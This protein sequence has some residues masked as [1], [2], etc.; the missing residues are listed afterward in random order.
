MKKATPEEFVRTWQTSNSTQE[1]ATALKMSRQSVISRA[2]FYRNKGIPLKSFAR[3][4]E[5][6]NVE[7][8]TKLANELV[9]KGK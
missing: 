2:G 7:K 3:K 1:V 5:H 4:F 9:K 6:V 8:L